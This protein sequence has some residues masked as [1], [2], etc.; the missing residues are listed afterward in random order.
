MPA[1]FEGPGVQFLYPENWTIE[2]SQDEDS[3]SVVVQ[4]PGTAFLMLSVHPGRPS[5]RDLLE[6]TLAALREDYPELEAEATEGEIGDHAAPGYDVQFFSL[7]LSNTCW[8][9]SYRSRR[10]SIL[11]LSQ[12]NDL[13]LDQAEPVLRAITKSMKLA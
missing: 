11:L 8:I 5:T 3:W 7:D 2:R 13:E 12:V 1:L 4:S 10:H 6:T 9:R